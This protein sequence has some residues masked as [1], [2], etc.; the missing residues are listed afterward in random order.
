MIDFNQLIDWF[1]LLDAV[2]V[3]A[4]III[5]REWRKS[6]KARIDLL[7]KHIEVAIKQTSQYASFEGA[8]KSLTEV[9][10]D[11]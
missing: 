2:L 8:I 5:W 4:I 9:L 1:G 11:S 6:E 10:K 7:E 3:I